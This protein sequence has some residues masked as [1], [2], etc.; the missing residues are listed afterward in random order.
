M[1]KYKWENR[2]GIMLADFARRLADCHDITDEQLEAVLEYL[3]AKLNR[4]RREG[5]AISFTAVKSKR[6]V[7]ESLIIRA[8]NVRT[9]DNAV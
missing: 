5:R 8:E 4:E 6:L 7:E 3:S 2:E 1:I 9:F